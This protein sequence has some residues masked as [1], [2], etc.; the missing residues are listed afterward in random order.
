MRLA[1]CHEAPTN[2]YAC[3]PCI[4]I[5]AGKRYPIYYPNANL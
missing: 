4:S 1:L 2:P 3:E 5:A